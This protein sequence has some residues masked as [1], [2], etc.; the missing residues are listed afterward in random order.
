MNLL[1]RDA[2]RKMLDDRGFQGTTLKTTPLSGCGA[3][4]GDIQNRQ[5]VGD[6]VLGCLEELKE[7]KAI[8]EIRKADVVFVVSHSQGSVVGMI[9]VSSLIDGGV[10]QPHVPGVQR[11][12]MLSM[13]GVFHGTHDKIAAN[14]FSS[15]WREASVEL[16]LLRDPSS[17]I[18]TMSFLPSVVNI[19]QVISTNSLY[20]Y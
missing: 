15:F 9:L 20:F 6:R 4:P 12:C 18:F 17:D 10:L 13:A 3:L 2:I 1:A 8:D 16:K 14:W 7:S 19:L 11:V 5:T